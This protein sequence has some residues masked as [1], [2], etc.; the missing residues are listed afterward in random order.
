MITNKCPPSPLLSP[1][2]KFWHECSRIWNNCCLN[3][4]LATTCCVGTV[5]YSSVG[6]G[7]CMTSALD[8]GI[9]FKQSLACL[10]KNCLVSSLEIFSGLKPNVRCPINKALRIHCVYNQ[11]IAQKLCPHALLIVHT[12]YCSL[13]KNHT[14]FTLNTVHFDNHELCLIN[15]W[16]PTNI[17]CQ[18]SPQILHLLPRCTP[19]TPRTTRTSVFMRPLDTDV[20]GIRTFCAVWTQKLM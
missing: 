18:Q 20:K 10:S 9:L 11:N 7:P 4:V 14:L 2:W 12:S 17:Q 19:G 5:Q 1:L 16:P 3:N 8:F 6:W 15:C 13:C